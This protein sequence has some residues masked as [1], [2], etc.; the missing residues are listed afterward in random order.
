MSEPQQKL[1]NRQTPF[2]EAFKAFIPTGWADWNDHYRDTVRDFWLSGQRTMRRGGGGGTAGRLAGAISGSADLFA[3]HGRTTLASV[4][5]ITAHDG[6][7]LY[8]L[9]A[10]DAK[11]NE[12]NL[13]NNADGT[14]DNHSWNH[15]HEGFSPDVRVRAARAATA[16]NMMATLLFSQGIPMITAG[17]ELLRSQDGNNNAYCQDNRLSWVDWRP[18]PLARSMFRTTQRLIRARRAFLAGQPRQFPT[19][20]E[21]VVL[22]WYAS[23]GEHMTAQRWQTD[24]ER[25]LQV[26]IAARGGDLAGLFVLNGTQAPVNAVLPLLESPHD[27]AAALPPREATFRLVLATDPQLDELT[28]NRWHTGDTVEVPAQ[29]VAM[30]AVT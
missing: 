30:F 8:D 23:T 19:R 5:F 28:G 7:T 3:P 14:N 26:V 21:D 10:Y 20:P 1:P 16:R 11:H 13:E 12:A 29:S 17:D 4:N 25:A 6:F 27:D 2:S 18:T 24:G 15:D 22:L 9:T